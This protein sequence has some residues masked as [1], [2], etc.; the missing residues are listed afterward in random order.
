MGLS[1]EDEAT[2]DAMQDECRTRLAINNN[3]AVFTHVNNGAIARTCCYSRLTQGG[4]GQNIRYQHATLSV[5]GSP[6]PQA[7][8]V[9]YFKS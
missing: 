1:A 6:C 3:A 5:G 2:G 9:F 4:I 7:H 8:T